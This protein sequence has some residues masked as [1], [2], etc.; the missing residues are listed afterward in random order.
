MAATEKDLGVQALRNGDLT[1]AVS[2]LTLAAQ[3]APND[4]SIFGY[5]GAA[6]GQLRMPE[7]AVQH[8][9]QAVRLA[10][11]SAPL[12][13]NLAQAQEMLGQQAAAL[14]SYRQT[15]NLEST[16]AKAQAAVARLAPGEAPMAPATGGDVGGFVLP[17]AGSAAAAPA[18]NSPYGAVP[19]IYA[20]PAPSNSPYGAVPNIYNQPVANPRP[21]PPSEPTL[22]GAA[23]GGPVAAPVPGLPPVPGASYAPPPTPAGPPGGMQPLGDWAPPPGSAPPAAEEPWRPAPPRPANV[24]QPDSQ[25]T[26]VS[27]PER[28]LPQ[29]WKTGH[30]YLAGM[31]SGLWW[32]LLGAILIFLTSLLMPKSELGERMGVVV[33]LCAMSLAFG[34]LIYGLIGIWGANSDDPETLC[35]NCGAALGVVAALVIVP[36]VGLMMSA[37]TVGAPLIGPIWIARAFGRGLG[38]RIAEMDA[39]MTV[40]HGPGGVMVTPVR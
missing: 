21:A 26:V 23:P 18:A 29:S 30:A 8:L 38:R 31:G 28:A 24:S 5:L 15:L 32:G 1:G 19:N 20:Q 39:S 3:K 11:Q 16:H 12:R 27:A 34:A 6:Y 14:E 13:Y 36:N 2:F 33:M 25:V 9:S 37:Y 4:P 22:I 17:G 7:Q 35:G 40:V 10:P